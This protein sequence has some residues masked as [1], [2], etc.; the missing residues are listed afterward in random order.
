MDYE[1]GS[2]EAFDRLYRDH[3]PKLVRTLYGVLGDAAAAEDC[4]QD[5]FVR[6]YQAWP[7]FKADRPPGAWL[8]R[9]ALNTAISYK[10]KQ[11][12]RHAADL[13]LR[14]GRPAGP[15][16]PSQQ[17]VMDDLVRAL[18]EL[19]P[20]VGMTFILRHYHGYSNRE[21]ARGLGVSE[22]MVGVR[23]QQAREHLA[24]RLGPEWAEPFPSQLPSGVSISDPDV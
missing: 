16:T 12:V 8:H 10:R 19:R 11:K 13:L 6:A 14:M 5:A 1:P 15:R 18:G 20:K 22:R 7:R 23:L 2:D 21:I 3:Y 17:I 24:R 9:I 4:V